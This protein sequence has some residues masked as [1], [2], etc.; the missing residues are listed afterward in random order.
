MRDITKKAL[1]A[2]GAFTSL[3]QY[4][5]FTDQLKKVVVHHPHLSSILGAAMVAASLL[6]DPKVRAA[7]GIKTQVVAQSS[8]VVA[9]T[10]PLQS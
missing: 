8:E 3:L 7:L 5:P 1:W 10:P 6:H 4:S 2:L 9:L